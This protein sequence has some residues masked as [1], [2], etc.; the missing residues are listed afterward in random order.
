[1]ASVQIINVNNPSLNI[2]AQKCSSFVCQLK[3]LMF[4]KSLGQNEGLLFI[5]N[6][7]DRLGSSIHM[8]FMNFDITV[9]WINSAKQVVDLKLARKWSLVHVPK[10]PAKFILELHSSKYSEF[11]IGDILE[12]NCQ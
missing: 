5:E 8:L 11:S 10:E 9:V 7:E 12:F 3:G 6:H 1:M 4:R 2:L